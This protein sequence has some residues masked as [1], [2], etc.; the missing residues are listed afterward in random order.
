MASPSARS[1][2]LACVFALALAPSGVLLEAQQPQGAAAPA[3]ATARPS[4]GPAAPSVALEG[5]A[6][7]RDADQTRRELGQLLDRQPPA[8]QEVLRLDPALLADPAYLVPYPALQA[9]IAAHP[10]IA[11]NPTFFLG[12]A[13]PARDD[14]S[15]QALA[16]RAWERVFEMVTIVMVFL[17]ITGVLV[18]LVR[19]LVDYRRWLRVSRVQAEAHAKLLDRLTQNDELLTYVQSPAGSAF[20]ASAPIPLDAGPRSIGAPFSRILWSVQAGVVLAFAGLG[21]FWA[22][23]RVAPEMAP[24]LSVLGI[25]ASMVG[26]GFA[27]SAFVAHALAR[28]LGLVD[29]TPPPAPAATPADSAS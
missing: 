13:R 6:E 27:V 24:P 12:E 7:R 29:R 2:W 9:F 10:E 3:P 5:E 18:W 16:L 11:R 23:Q 19:T 28:R 25:L 21:L 22:S 15:P 17:S 4:T 14:T 8:L 1:P 20:L 26:A